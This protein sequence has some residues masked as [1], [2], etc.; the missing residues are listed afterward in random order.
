MEAQ[1]D[2]RIEYWP[3]N[4]EDYRQEIRNHCQRT[5]EDLPPGF[6]RRNIRQL[7]GMYAG[8]RAGIMK[9]EYIAKELLR[10][11]LTDVEEVDRPRSIV[12]D[13]QIYDRLKMVVGQISGRPEVR[14]G[15]QTELF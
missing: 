12:Q 7:R 1:R 10:R 9:R 4:L 15:Q 14:Q 3:R 11:T 6:S 8:I 13:E 5:G 2:F